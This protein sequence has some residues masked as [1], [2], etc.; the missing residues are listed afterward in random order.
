MKV[1][2]YILVYR[3]Q[4]LVGIHLRQELLGAGDHM[5]AR[6]RAFDKY[7]AEFEPK[8]VLEASNLTG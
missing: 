3:E 8:K 6:Q 2:D 1:L 4:V 5:S 7:K